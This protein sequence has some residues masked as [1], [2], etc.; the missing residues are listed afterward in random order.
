MLNKKSTANA[1]LYLWDN[2][3]GVA[4]ISVVA[5]HASSG[6]GSFEK[7]S[8][9]WIF[10]LALRQVIDFAVPIFL[11]ISGYFAASADTEN[12]SSYYAARLSRI[13]PP[14]IAWTLIYIAANSTIENISIFIVAKGLL[15]GTGIG[16]GYFVIVLVQFILLTP[17]IAKIQQKRSHI[18]I[19]S[20]ATIIGLTFI[21]FF[22]AFN[23][24]HPI[25]VFP[26][27]ALPFLSWYPFYHAGYFIGRYRKNHSATK[28]ENSSTLLTYSTFLALSI[29]EGLFWGWSN[30]YSFGAS[31]LK[32]SSIAASLFLLILI[33]NQRNSPLSKEYKVLTW[34]GRN[35]YAIYLIHLLVLSNI[36]PTLQQL[37]FLHDLQP[38]YISTST[39][40]ALAVTSAAIWSM[41][42]LMPKHVSRNLLG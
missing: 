9:N 18:A 27:Y 29:A 3:R 30:N 2:W 38:L 11:A 13:L 34:L 17:F 41:R 40:A 12:K 5:I 21:Y 24:D 37:H 36:Q 6:T 22:A 16:I 19:M 28:T 32:I 10:G 7:W 42:A 25:G 20:G 39:I 4:I 1:R 26:A 15:F 33:S 31:Q 35:S 8:F 23:T 14:Y